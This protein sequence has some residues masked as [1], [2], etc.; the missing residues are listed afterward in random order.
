MLKRTKLYV[1]ME[2]F[3]YKVRNY[4]KSAYSFNKQ[5]STLTLTFGNVQCN[6]IITPF[7]FF[8]YL[9]LFVPD[10]GEAKRK[11]NNF[12]YLCLFIYST[13]APN[14]LERF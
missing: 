8:S 7:L 10:Y 13:V 14:L 6:E 12:G 1:G 3:K 5:I 11:G 4:K 9:F 2:C